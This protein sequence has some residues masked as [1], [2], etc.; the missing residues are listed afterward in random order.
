M[1]QNGFAVDDVHLFPIVWGQSALLKQISLCEDKLDEVVNRFMLDDSSSL[2]MTKE[3]KK[4][5][6]SLKRWVNESETI[7]AFGVCFGMDW[8]VT[9][10]PK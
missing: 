4:Q 8:V 2:S 3:L 7:N 1:E 9:A 6:I 10:H 5:A